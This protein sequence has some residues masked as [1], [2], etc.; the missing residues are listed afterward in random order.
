MDEQP[1]AFTAGSSDVGVAALKAVVA[2][3]DQLLDAAHSDVTAVIMA[4]SRLRAV[5][6]TK[7]IISTETSELLD[8]AYADASDIITIVTELADTLAAF[9]PNG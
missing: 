7:Q 5:I 3:Y 6:T 8:A 2:Q 4:A 9:D 1:S